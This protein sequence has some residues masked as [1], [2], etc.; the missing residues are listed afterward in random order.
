MKPRLRGAATIFKLP[1]TIA[2][3]QLTAE[4]TGGTTGQIALS[5]AGSSIIKIALPTGCGGQGPD[6]T[7]EQSMRRL[8]V[9][10]FLLN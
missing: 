2:I 5:H 6:G 3:G 4:T 10:V 7:A 1:M 8:G 9:S